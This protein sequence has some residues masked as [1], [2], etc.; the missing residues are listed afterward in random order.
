M[1]DEKNRIEHEIFL[2]STRGGI[3]LENVDNNN[4]IAEQK[5]ELEKVKLDIRRLKCDLSA[6]IRKKIRENPKT[7]EIV[8]QINVKEKIYK[9]LEREL[10]ALMD[11]I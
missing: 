6:E 7:E 11:D 3:K 4:R 5:S 10:D 2:N 1:N 8:G 9:V